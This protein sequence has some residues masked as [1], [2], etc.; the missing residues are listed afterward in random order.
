MGELKKRSKKQQGK[1]LGLTTYQLDRWRSKLKVSAAINVVN[2]CVAGK[3][4]LSSSRIKAIELVLRKSLPDLQSIE[5]NS[6]NADSVQFTWAKAKRVTETFEA[7]SPIV[8]ITPDKIEEP[9]EAQK[10][11]PN[12]T[13]SH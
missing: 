1:S 11:V 2:D 8:D 5:V 13:T 12:S 6:S 10:P 4:E 7:A 9:Q 3:V